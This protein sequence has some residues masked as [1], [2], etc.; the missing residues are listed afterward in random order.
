MPTSHLSRS[1]RRCA[2]SLFIVANLGTILFMNRPHALSE[3]V[4]ERV[5]KGSPSGA[6]RLRQT[7]WCIHRY[8]HVVG[9]DN[10][11]QMFGRQSRF[12]WWY[13]ITATY[14]DGRT[15]QT[16]PLP[17]PTQ[18]ARTFWQRVLF[19]F[20]EA[21]FHLNIYSDRL[22]RES[23]SRYLA[24]QFP[25]RDERAIRTITWQ[26]AY[27]PILPP[28]ESVRTRRLVDPHCY[29][30]TL[31]EFDVRRDDDASPRR[32][33]PLLPANDLV[34]SERAAR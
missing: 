13:V 20:R 23:Y 29:V 31:D 33:R 7:G 15:S 21:K 4:V 26:L 18:S 16:V 3:S 2:I 27:Q 25:Q 17:T 32:Y 24:R 30:Q 22:A 28:D 19:D 10:R 1:L 11:W 8:A 9:L 5:A 14:S 12:N 6:Y 34:R